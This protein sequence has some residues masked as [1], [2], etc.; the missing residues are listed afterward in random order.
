MS[1][2]NPENKM[3]DKNMKVI[4]LTGGIGSG[5]S[6]ATSFLR[7]KNYTVY[8][9]DE[10]AREA[11]LPGEPAL[12]KLA[13]V[14]GAEILTEEG[15]L[16]RQ[17]LADMVFVSDEKTQLLNSIMH[18]DI[19]E[20][21]NKY[22]AKRSLYISKKSGN[23]TTFNTVFLAAPLLLEGNLPKLCNEIWLVTADDN[24]R[25]KRASERDGVS[26]DKIRDRMKYQMSEE[27]KKTLVDVVIENNGT[28]DDLFNK[29]ED[30]LSESII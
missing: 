12:T 18:K 20:R 16:N 23:N 24:V 11:V 5:K 9:A 3:F 15:L 22:L 25:I 29:L 1:L 7:S 27:E 28:E 19:N 6:L 2:S 17:K 21:I 14:F 10:I 30:L 13:E 4:G 26:E 8:D